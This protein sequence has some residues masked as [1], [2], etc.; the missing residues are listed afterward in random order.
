VT[1]YVHATDASG[2][3]VPNFGA[4]IWESSN[5]T[6]ASVVK[7]DTAAI[8][9]G[10][11]TGESII[12]ASV[13]KLRAQMSVQVG[14]VPVI[15]TAPA[16]AA[17]TGYRG[18]PVASQSIAITNGG[19]GTLDGLS[20]TTSAAWLQASLA[21]GVTSAN[22][23]ATLKVQ[24]TVGTLSDGSYTGSV[25]IASSARGVASKTIPVTFQV[26]PVPI[27]F[28]IEAMTLPTQAGSAGQ[29][30]AQ[31]PAVVVRAA[32][33]TPVP[34]VAVT[35]SVNGG[36]SIVPSGVVNTDASGIASLVSWTLSAQ[37]GALQT[38]TVSAPGLAGSPLTFTAT[39]LSASKIVRVSGDGQSTVLARPLPEPLVVRVTDPNDAPVP[40]ATVTFVAAAGTVSPSSAV[41]DA[42]GLASATWTLGASTGTQQLTVFLV[43]PPGSPSVIFTATATGATTLSKI[44][45]DGQSAAAGSDLPV[46]V[47]VRVTG[48]NAQAVTGTT[49]TFTPAEG[50]GTTT[51]ITAVTDANGEA[52]ARWTMPTS[53]GTKTLTVSVV[54][55]T[56]VA[57]VTFT[58]TATPPP[59]GGITIADGDNQNGRISAALPRQVVAR[60]VTTI[61]TGVPGVSVTF[62]PATG[63]GQSFSPV[64]GTTDANGEVRTTWTLGPTLGTYTATVASPGLASRTITAAA[65][66]LPPNV[67][68]F[69]GAAAKMPGAT[70]PGA[71]EQPVLTYSGPVSGEVALD[72][73][74][75]FITPPLPLG[76]YTLA[77]VSK[78]GAFPTT[79]MYGVALPGGVIT[80]VG[81]ISVAYAGSGP[82]RIA[83]H[84]CP[85]VGDANGTAT[86]RLYN[87]INGDQ[88][89]SLAY[90]WTIPFSSLSQ[91]TAAYG[92]YTMVIT[93]QATDPTKTCGV[94]RASVEHTWTTP[95]GTTTIPL[96]VLS[97]P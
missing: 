7:S 62:T 24:P 89:G 49:V 32:D 55:P 48:V 29:P 19:S 11:A 28:K 31:A 70:P 4:V 74:G 76:T 57:T 1:V 54:V 45:G 96:I 42:N 91:A 95:N 64:S 92:I 94:Y 51:P 26:A 90:T 87:G 50:S 40:N 88:G 33:N 38:V 65:N 47:R 25:T 60:V 30:V 81:T 8:I 52:S 75:A 10:L 85:I 18:F 79:T 82:L 44:A 69:S 53:V 58:A 67:G 86:I 20:V 3:R 37:A 56:G 35:F 16:V 73:S 43:G 61:G 14:Q 39:S 80:S 34:G 36:G 21:G 5:A 12:S 13:G 77:I 59:I 9:T 78:T 97:N 22:P 6:V 71:A 23:T 93:T 41:T 83:V 66:L 84:A 63:T 17:F 2:S 46:P 27:A 15:V 72:A 68:A